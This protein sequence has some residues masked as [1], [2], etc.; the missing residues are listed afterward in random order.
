MPLSSFPAQGIGL[1]RRK[2]L[3]STAKW[4]VFTIQLPKE[5]LAQTKAFSEANLYKLPAEIYALSKTYTRTS[6]H[7]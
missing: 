4:S 3:E 2:V 6:K 1:L 7:N 5:L